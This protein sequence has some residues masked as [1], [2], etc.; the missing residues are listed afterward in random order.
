MSYEKK[1]FESASIAKCLALFEQLYNDMLRLET[2]AL[3]YWFGMTGTVEDSY[4]TYFMPLV[5]VP[6]TTVHQ[7]EIFKNDIS[8]AF[9]TSRV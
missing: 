4:P 2:M 8:E 6:K 7:N 1:D 3:N 9:F 5:D